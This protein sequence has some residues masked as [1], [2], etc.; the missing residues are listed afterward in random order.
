MTILTYLCGVLQL[1]T[2]GKFK[3]KTILLWRKIADHPDARRILAMF[4][5]ADVTIIDHQRYQPPPNVIAGQ[6]LIA[7]KRTLMLG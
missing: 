7:G 3:P 2:A 4:P 1:D 5:T 6:A